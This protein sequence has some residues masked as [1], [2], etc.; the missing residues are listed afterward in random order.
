MSVSGN[1]RAPTKLYIIRVRASGEAFLDLA[2]VESI[3]LTI[4]DGALR[5]MR[6]L[7]LGLKADPSDQVRRDRD[8]LLPLSAQ[9]M[10]AAL[11]GPIAKRPASETR[12][13]SRP[14]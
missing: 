10:A 11:R 4:P 9:R 13:A 6:S 5:Q 14:G 12:A 8:E 2:G 1:A 7:G 3:E